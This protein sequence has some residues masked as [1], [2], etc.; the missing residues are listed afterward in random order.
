VAAQD[1]LAGWRSLLVRGSVIL[2][3]LVISMIIIRLL[4]HDPI[5][6]LGAM[7]KGSFGSAYGIRNTIIVAIPLLIT[8][9]GLTV[10][11]SMKF[12]NIGAEGQLLMGGI[13]A[14]LITRL[15]PEQT[16]GLLMVLLMMAAAVAGG[17]LWAL[18][19]GLFRAWSGTN[20]TLFT[21]MMNYLAIKLTVYLRCVMWKDP[22]AM[23]FPQ[24]AAIPEQARLPRLF[25]LPI[26]W[27]IALAVVVAVT[28]FLRLTKKGYEIRVVGESD[29]T[30]H[31]AGINVRKVILTGVL[32]SGG[33][34]GLA[35]VTKLT[36]VAYT[37]SENLGGGSGFT[38]IIVAWLSQL[39][40]PVMVLVSLLFA[41]MQQGSMA[42]ELSLGIPAS[43]TKI[44]EGLILF[45][46]LSAEFFIRYRIIIERRHVPDLPSEPVE[47]EAVKRS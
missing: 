45:A 18:I 19:P 4:G 34:I 8:S 41:A 11:F 6:A 31:Y 32:I 47:A 25:G 21:L 14:T 33:L 2:A 27:I 13:S 23:G 3:S 30:A 22:K 42:M 38:A 12:W 15:L 9:A 39:H 36:G 28:V 46:A 5:R 26:G 17:A 10:A 7:I 20:E 35:G 1:D 37:L 40:V 24:I 29:R 16:N 44:I 43:V